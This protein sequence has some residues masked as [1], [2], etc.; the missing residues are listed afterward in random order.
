[1]ILQRGD[2]RLVR[3]QKENI[4]LVRRWRNDPEIQKRME[5]RTYI[6]E[7][8]QSAW[9]DRVNNIYNG[10]FLISVADEY[11]GLIHASDIDWE[12]NIAGNC[13]IFVWD[14]RYLESP[15]TAEASLLFT[16]LGFCCGI[17]RIFIKI[18]KDNIASIFYNQTMGYKLLPGQEDI[19]NQMYE[20]TPEIYFNATAKLRSYAKTEDKINVT[21]KKEEAVEFA[22]LVKRFIANSGKYGITFTSEIA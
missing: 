9:F 10:Y 16:D 22:F 15:K 1:M 12:K 3:L 6:T 18:L 21:L 13:G 19:M 4:E 7:E 17:E 2:I 20:L 8:M 11:I 5:Y 14:K